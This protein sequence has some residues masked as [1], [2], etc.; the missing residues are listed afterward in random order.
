MNPNLLFVSLN[1][2]QLGK[3]IAVPDFMTGKTIFAILWIATISE[4][5]GELDCK[6]FA[7]SV[8]ICG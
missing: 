3:T 4:I 7:V 6:R 1:S 5:G 8:G 2:T